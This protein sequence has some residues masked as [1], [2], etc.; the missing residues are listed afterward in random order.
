MKSIKIVISLFLV[1]L[2]MGLT[3][4][5]KDWLDEQPL[6]S[7]S[8]ASFWKSESD[9]LLAL[10]GIYPKTVGKWLASELYGDEMEYILSSTDDACVK[11]GSPG[12]P[13][14]GQFQYPSDGNVIGPY[15]R[16]AYK[17][18]FR[19]NVF[20][21]NIDKV[22]MDATKKAQFVAEARFMRANEYFW[23]L[24]WWGGVPLITKALTIPEANSQTRNSRQEIVDFCLAE[25]TAAAADLPPT[26]P[27][28][29]RGRILK[30]AALAEKGRL[31]MIEKRWAEAAAAFKEIIDM[32][33][34]IIDPRYK[35]I[36]EEGGE[37]SK[38]IILS[39][40][41]VAGIFGNNHN[42]KNY[43]PAFY[44]GYQEAQ[45]IS[46]FNR[47]LFNE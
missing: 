21:A 43:H 4:C 20:L 10:T 28:S 18:I 42:Q 25:L 7:L 15:Y 24:Q 36:F 2:L 26:R 31:L 34:H 1:I 30:A 33:A 3:E 45:C 14:L 41:Y 35:A 46:G 9:A 5:Q 32:N 17:G 40:I 23:L 6:S 16:A 11:E 12:T 8:D 37:T 22:T 13:E 47:C 27:D 29:E 38:E 44:G 19:A 39:T